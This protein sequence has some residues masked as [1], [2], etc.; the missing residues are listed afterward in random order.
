MWQVDKEIKEK[1]REAEEVLR[2]TKEAWLPLWAHEKYNEV[3]KLICEQ[4]VISYCESPSFQCSPGFC[5]SLGQPVVRKQQLNLSSAFL[6]M[7]S[8]NVAQTLEA[9]TSYMESARPAMEEALKTG[10]RLSR[11]SSA[12]VVRAIDFAQVKSKE[13][14]EVAHPHIASLKAFLQVGPHIKEP[15]S[16]CSLPHRCAYTS[17]LT[18]LLPV[19]D[20]LDKAQKAMSSAMGT[21]FPSAWEALKDKLQRISLPP[22]VRQPPHGSI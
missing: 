15:V 1:L 9:M 3:R 11:Q 21:H 8:Y 6:S 22:Q 10:H 14:W 2:L 4:R 16:K 18:T 7:G 13:A 5:A 17:G 12:N 20:N 19:Q